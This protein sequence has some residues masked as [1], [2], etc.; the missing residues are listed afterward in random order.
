MVPELAEILVSPRL[1]AVA[2]PPEAML[3]MVESA[4]THVTDRVRSWVEPSERVPVAVNCWSTPRGTE[5]AAG[6]RAIDTSTAFVT[7]RFVDPEIEPEV[8]VMAALPTETPLARPL[9]V[10]LATLAAL[11]LQDTESVRS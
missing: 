4:D 1:R 6:E 2:R 9:A 8:A 7:V 10:M 5:G 3:A 11:A